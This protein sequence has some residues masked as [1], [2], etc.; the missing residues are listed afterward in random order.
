M[1]FSYFQVLIFKDEDGDVLSNTKVLNI[2][3]CN[4]V[5]FPPVGFPKSK[6]L[7]AVQ[8]RQM[9]L[10]HLS[11]GIFPFISNLGIEDINELIIDGFQGQTNLAH[12][13][14]KN[15]V[16]S[17]I[18]EDSFKELKNLEKIVF[19]N[20]SINTVAANAMQIL[21]SNPKLFVKFTNCKVSFKNY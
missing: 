7:K 21:S 13:E 20:V 11:T 9:N 5:S 2:S 1:S 16:L 15:S 18:N 4:F 17:E 8:I 3:T 14:I 6:K 12:L 10:F 19:Q